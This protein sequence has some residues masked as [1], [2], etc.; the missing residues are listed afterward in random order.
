MHSAFQWI[1]VEFISRFHILEPM[2]LY[3]VASV[4]LLEYMSISILFHAVLLT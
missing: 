2:F 4:Y 3:M 1:S